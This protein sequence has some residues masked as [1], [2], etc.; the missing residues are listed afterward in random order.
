MPSL[1]LHPL[2]YHS[3]FRSNLDY[4]APTKNPLVLWDWR[5]HSFPHPSLA[6]SSVSSS[7]L[8]MPKSLR[9]QPKGRSIYLGSQFL[10]GKPIALRC[11]DSGLWGGR[12]SWCWE[13][14]A[15]ALYMTTNKK[16][17]EPHGDWKNIWPPVTL[18]SDLLFPARP[19]LPKAPKLP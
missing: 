16:Q 3:P 17:R 11:T 13:R 2:S 8:A 14:G 1:N 5:K 19:H 7:Y 12:T 18:P 6:L 10:R 4:P 15:E 9:E